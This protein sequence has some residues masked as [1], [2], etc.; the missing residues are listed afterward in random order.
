MKRNSVE[1]QVLVRGKPVTE[2]RHQGKA[3]IEGREGSE[4]ELRVKN[5]LGQRVLIVPSVDGLSVMDGQEASSQSQGY[6]LGAY[7]EMLIPGWRLD[8]DEVA[9]FIFEDMKASY[10]EQVGKGTNRGVIGLKAFAE[11]VIYRSTPIPFRP[12]PWPVTQP[13]QPQPIIWTTDHTT[14][15][16]TGHNV[17]GANTTGDTSRMKTR[18]KTAKVEGTLGLYSAEVKCAVTPT[19]AGGEQIMGQS[20]EFVH[21]C[22]FVQTSDEPAENL[23]VGFGEAAEHKVQEVTFNKGHSLATFAIYY[24]SRKGLEKRGITVVSNQKPLPEPFPASACT[25]PPGWAE[26]HSQ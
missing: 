26:T 20:G 10:A 24:D 23:G 11:K 19:S 12:E 13:W 21:D 1:L 9:R 4:F 5:N 3:F 22:N 17:I 14:I 25:P 16:Y 2:F 7:Q 18:S 8:N 15:T 6:V